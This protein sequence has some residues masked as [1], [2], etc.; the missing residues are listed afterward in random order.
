ME[1]C[2]HIQFCTSL[3]ESIVNAINY[4]SLPLSP[5]VCTETDFTMQVGNYKNC[6]GCGYAFVVGALDA[7]SLPYKHVYH[8]VCFAHMC[9]K[10]GAFLIH[11]CK[12]VVPDRAKLMLGLTCINI[13]K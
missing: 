9:K 2:K 11:G 7:F 5:S 13:K 12:Q 6:V 4:P 8:M 10:Y 1:A 3:Q